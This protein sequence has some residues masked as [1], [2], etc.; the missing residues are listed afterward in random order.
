MSLKESFQNTYNPFLM[1]TWLILGVCAYFIISEI[2]G[3]R[4]QM[5]MEFFAAREA[6]TD[7]I[8]ESATETAMYAEYYCKD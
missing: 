4:E 2:K 7:H 5:T 6:L 8:S 1:I 3:L